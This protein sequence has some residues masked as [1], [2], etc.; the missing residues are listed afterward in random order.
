ML[1]KK[2]LNI[3]E[4]EFSGHKGCQIGRPGDLLPSLYT[5][6][7]SARQVSPIYEHTNVLHTWSGGGLEGWDRS[8]SSMCWA[9]VMVCQC[10]H[11]SARNKGEEETHFMY[12][13]AQPPNASLGPFVISVQFDNPKCF[14]LGQWHPEWNVSFLFFPME[15][16]NILV[17]SKF[18]PPPRKLQFF[19]NYFPSKNHFGGNSWPA[20]LVS[21]L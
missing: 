5:R 2:I 9:N 6:G 12:P 8:S 16:W 14:H 3:I 15:N 13:T 18:P 17:K 10:G 7:T 19:R 4:S 21:N 1:L 20:L 11:L